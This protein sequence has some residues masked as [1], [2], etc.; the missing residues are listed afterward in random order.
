MSLTYSLVYTPL[1]DLRRVVNYL[2]ADGKVHFRFK[3]FE[4]REDIVGFE[5]KLNYLMTY[6]FNYSYSSCYNYSPSEYVELPKGI[7]KEIIKDF[8]KSPD[9]IQIYNIVKLNIVDKKF[10][11][12]K[13]NLNYSLTRLEDGNSKGVSPFGSID[14]DCAPLRSPGRRH[15]KGSIQIFLETLKIDLYSYLFNDGY[16]IAINSTRKIKDRDKL[17]KKQNRIYEATTADVIKLW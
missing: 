11:G 1:R 14:D 15:A 8:L 4:K 3:D 12:F 6:L 2:Y 9:V 13:A 10:K 17:I 7:I 5:E 16:S